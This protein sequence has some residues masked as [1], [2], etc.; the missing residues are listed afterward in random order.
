MVSSLDVLV[1]QLQAPPRFDPVYVND[2]DLDDLA[3]FF[4]MA[5]GACLERLRT[6]SPQ[7]L[8]DQW[9]DANP[10]TPE[11]IAAFYQ[12]T[13]LYIWELMQ[14]HTSVAR[15]SFWRTLA[16][17]AEHYPAERGFQRILDYGCGIGTDSLYLARLGYTVTCMDLTG[18]AFRFAQHRF[19]RR[20]MAASFLDASALPG[21]HDRSFDTVICFDVF[22]HLPDPLATAS[23]LVRVLAPGG[24]LAQTV[25]FA[26]GGNHPCHLHSNFRRFGGLGWHIHL[27]GLGLR[28]DRNFYRKTSGVWRAIQRTRFVG[29]R[30]TGLWLTW[31]R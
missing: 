31:H 22:E 25:L 23:D 11:E 1:P 29:W 9:R 14:W 12:T 27:A 28:H 30:M 7:E 21:L 24:V 4:N 26:D 19:A 16:H 6:Y 10:Q 17:L 5:E 18:P 2:E 15:Q 3:T 8:A 13:D 20:G